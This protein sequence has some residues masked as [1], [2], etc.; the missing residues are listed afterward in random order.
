[1]VSARLLPLLLLVP[2]AP[3]LANSPEAPAAR[4]VASVAPG[5]SS[6]ASATRS[7]ATATLAQASAAPA[8][9]SSAPA[10]QGGLPTEAPAVGNRTAPA[11][12][13]ASSSAPAARNLTSAAQSQSSEAPAARNPTPDEAW[14]GPGEGEASPRDSTPDDTSQ[15]QAPGEVA[16]PRRNS[17]PDDTSWQ[18]FPGAT[19]VPQGQDAA[20]LPRLPEVP[21]LVPVDDLPP[22]PRPSVAR[23]VRTPE[24]PPPV[25]NRV[26]LLGARTVGPGGFAAGFSL[27]FPTLSA[28]A[29]VG[30]LSRL[31]ALVGVDSLYGMMTEVRAGARWMAL[32]GGPRW[33]LGLAVEGG[34]AFFLRPASVEDKGARY[35]SG[36]RNWN[37][38]PGLVGNYQLEG[39]R[40]ARLFF[41]VRY[42]LSFDTEPI[43]RTPLGGLPPSVVSGSAFPL[44]VGAEVPLSEKTSYSV[45]VGGDVRTRPED[46]EFMPVLSVGIVT[47]L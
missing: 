28:R 1:M 34:H 29:A 22:S 42:H 9:R 30:V 33:S 24:G 45:T 16:A 46:A 13:Q 32:D 17:A 31:D 23:R 40:R 12:A 11:R 26:S 47:G 44:R 5:R 25:R 7:P 20:A 10:T 21:P 43:Q 36:R 2:G 8:A 3:A 37:V 27:G 14:Q 41:D 35:L 6:E 4:T 38:L 39:P 18:G 15:E 19:A